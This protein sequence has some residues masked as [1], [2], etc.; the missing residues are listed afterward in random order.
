MIAATSSGAPAV[1]APVNHWIVALTVTLAT[2]MEVL[3]TSIANVA[4]PYIA[5]NLSV[6]RSQS[7]WVL[8]SYLV[9][10]AIVLPLSGW[11]IGLI[12]RKR[13]YMSCVALFT[14]ASACCGAAPSIEILILCRVLQGLAGGGLQPSEQGILVDTFPKAQLGMA[15]AIYGVA[16]VV[17]PILGPTLGGYISDNYT[18]RWIF[19]INVPVGI[20]SLILTHFIVQDP[21]GMEERV[22]ATR[23][24]ILDI[25]Y[26][27]LGLVSLGLGSLEVIYAKGQEW[28]WYN[29]PFWRAQFFMVSAVVGLISFFVW[30]Y[31]HPNPIINVRLLGDRTF[32]SCGVI[33]F[34]SFAVLYGANQNLPQMLQELFGYDAFHAGLILSPGAFFTMALM[35][36]VGFLI[37]KKVDNRFILPVGLFCLAISCYWLSRFTLNASPWALNLPRCLMMSGIGCL[38]VPLNNSA[39]NY[40][41]KDQINNATGIFNMLRNEGGSF[42]IAISTTMIDRRAQFHQS[43]LAEHVVSTN[44]AVDRWTDYYT[45]VRMVRGGV[46]EWMAQQQAFG[47]LQ[48]MVGR[49]YRFYAYMD[50]YLIFAVMSL[51]ALPFVFLMKKSV[52]KGGVAPH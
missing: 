32:R 14:I 2:F 39:Y 33:I 52:A 9:A 38:F 37:G 17:A 21:P 30:E 22:K 12:G 41:P 29:D 7:T 42:G 3:D 44:P 40:L 10:N 18:W 45:Q 46:T 28:D 6:G 50:I 51:V 35:P 15:M 1:K 16:V 49:Q 24:K 11:L 13:F 23:G 48:Q 5:G 26:I 20:I 31:Y 34:L 19:Y 8:T 4:L 27:G 36:V 47:M 25:D 43:R